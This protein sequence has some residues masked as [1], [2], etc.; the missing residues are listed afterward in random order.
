MAL[1]IYIYIESSNSVKLW[2]ITIKNSVTDSHNKKNILLAF[3]GLLPP[4]KMEP[5]HHETL[6]F[7]VTILFHTKAANSTISGTS[8]LVRIIHKKK[9]RKREHQTQHIYSH[10]YT[11]SASFSFP[12]RPYTIGIWQHNKACTLDSRHCLYMSY[13]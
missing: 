1:Y 2:I 3:P 4:M 6:N 7:F 12:L 13:E 10:V 5:V 8:I 9:K 11:F